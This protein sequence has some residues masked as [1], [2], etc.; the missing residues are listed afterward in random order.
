MSSKGRGGA[1]GSE[2]TYEGDQNPELLDFAHVHG[3]HTMFNWNVQHLTQASV[4]LPGTQMPDYNFK[5]EESRALTLLLLSWR[6]LPYP[7]NTSRIPNWPQRRCNR[8]LHQ[9]RPRLR[10]RRLSRL[11]S[12]QINLKERED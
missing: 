6:R 5:P 4:V 3:A 8:R 9:P 11:E 7:R 1:S 10:S 12:C 2:L